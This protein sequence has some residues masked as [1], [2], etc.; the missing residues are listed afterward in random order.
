MA[1]PHRRTAHTLR[2]QVRAC[3]L[4]HLVAHEVAVSALVGSEQLLEL[5]DAVRQVLLL[6]VLLQLRLKQRPENE[7]ST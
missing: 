5:P 4:A 1:P 7:S 2:V 6:E 3:A